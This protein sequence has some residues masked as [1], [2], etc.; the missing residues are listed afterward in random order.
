[1]MRKAYAQP[2]KFNAKACSQY[3]F[4][5]HNTKIALPQH[6]A[7]LRELCDTLHN[8]IIYFCIYYSLI[9][10]LYIRLHS[11]ERRRANDAK[12]TISV[13]CRFD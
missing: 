3:L 6:C 12:G 2:H 7:M 8:M 1:M 9:F 11:S 4:V 5:W 13:S 10:G